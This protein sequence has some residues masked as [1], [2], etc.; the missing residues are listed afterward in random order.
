M[1]KEN[2]GAKQ[3]QKRCNCLN[4]RKI[5]RA[6]ARTQRHETAHSQKDSGVESKIRPE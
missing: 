3:T 2:T 5:L 1:G 4:H 6:P